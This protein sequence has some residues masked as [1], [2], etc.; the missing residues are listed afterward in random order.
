M[1]HLTPRQNEMTSSA[2]E[3]RGAA[4]AFAELKPALTRDEAL[5]EANRCLYCYDAP[6]TRVCPTSIDVPSFIQK[7]TTGN[8][9]G[10]AKTILE[11]NILGYACARVC[12][13]EELCEGACVLHDL[14]GAKPVAIGQL[15]RYATEPVVFGDDD[16]PL[17]TNAADNGRKVAVVGAGP[18]GLGCAAALTRLGYA[19]DVFEA[20]ERPGGLNATGVAEYKLDQASALAEI[21]WIKQGGVNIICKKP[22]DDVEALLAQGYDALF[23]GVGLAE[24]PPLGLDGED[25]L[26]CRDVLEFIAELKSK[27]MAEVSLAGKRVAVL[28][29]GNTAID[30]VTQSARLG[31]DKVYL[32]YRRGREQMRAYD[33]EI[34]LARLDGAEFLTW[35]RP[36]EIIGEGANVIA[37]RCQRTA[38]DDS[39]KLVDVDGETVELAVDV[40]LRATGQSKREGFLA[41]ISGL[42][43]EK[44]GVVKV[45]ENGKTSHA[46]IWAGGDCV[47]G[48][49]EVVNAV[50]EGKKA[51]EHIHQTLEA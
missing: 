1:H 23:L 46:K 4:T 35:A 30:G 29:G 8:L 24:V 42:E 39:G 17:L 37:L 28:G 9:R 34:E 33:H 2:H 50:A 5:A 26:G 21:E 44:N 10:S 41:S 18:A 12:P 25:L 15:Q 45:D 32:V 7:I 19:V 3:N 22:I 47:N 38:L 14:H 20:A 11:A 31:A 16:P 40:I 43:R 27:P 51:A 13:T 49:K 48:G 6:C 36:L